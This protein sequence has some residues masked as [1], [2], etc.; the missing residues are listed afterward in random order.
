[1]K[2]NNPLKK[3][4][5]SLKIFNL[6]AKRVY[7]VSKKRK[8][9][10]KWNDAQKWTSANLFKKYKA[11]PISKIRLTDVDKEVEAIL[12]SGTIPTPEPEV[13]TS[14]FSLTDSDIEDIPFWFLE[15]V[16]FGGN[17]NYG[18]EDNL[19]I[20]IEVDGFLSTGIIKKSDISNSDIKNLTND[21]RKSL[22]ATGENYLTIIFKRLQVPNTPDTTNPCNTYL[23]ITSE[24]SNADNTTEEIDKV[25]K[26]EDL[27]EDEKQKRQ[28]REDEKEAKKKDKKNKKSIQDKE[29][30]KQ[31]EPKIKGVVDTESEKYKAL[32]F[33][34]E[35]LK[36]DVK[37]GLIT[38]KQYQDRQKLILDKF[39]LGGE[40]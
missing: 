23:L 4:I 7:K 25:V 31:V 22:T 32:T 33:A 12:D 26:E 24:N 3:K 17:G 8:L 6:L 29:R 21:I 2:K 30:P 28:Q 18:F 36:Q 15:D 38:K 10:W 5:N 19:K 27:S 16:I 39:N 34:L 13:C 37:D 9:G 1:M 20:A 11:T 40:I 14:V 35:M